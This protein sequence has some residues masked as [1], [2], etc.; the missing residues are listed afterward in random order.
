MEAYGCV[1][2]VVEA[3]LLLS[4]LGKNLMF[5]VLR[6][7]TGF[8]QCVLSDELVSWNDLLLSLSELLLLH[9]FPFHWKY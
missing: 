9:P 5:V 3:F 2:K 6:D 8:L 1:K 7:G 4:Q